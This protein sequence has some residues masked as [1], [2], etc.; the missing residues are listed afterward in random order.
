MKALLACSFIW[1]IINGYAEDN[2]QQIKF[3]ILIGE[4]AGWQR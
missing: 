3:K 1:I 2:Y 4:K